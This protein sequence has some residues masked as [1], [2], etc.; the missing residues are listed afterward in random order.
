MLV[1]DAAPVADAEN[2]NWP[3]ALFV[4][5]LLDFISN[6]STDAFHYSLRNYPGVCEEKDKQVT[7][8]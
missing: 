1:S 3:L 2:G 8:N 5:D 7:N 4:H 6:D